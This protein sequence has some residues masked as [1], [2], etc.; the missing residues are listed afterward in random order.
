MLKIEE[1]TAASED[2]DDLNTNAAFSQL[3]NPSGR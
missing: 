3:V 2:T 1:E